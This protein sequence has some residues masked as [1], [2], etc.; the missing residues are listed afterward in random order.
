MFWLRNKKIKFSLPSLNES[1]VL[2]FCSKGTSRNYPDPSK[3]QKA[4]SV[5]FMKK[6][7]VLSDRWLSI[8]ML[9]C[10][11]IGSVCV[12]GQKIL[13]KS[14]NP[15]TESNTKLFFP[16]FF[17]NKD[18]SVHKVLL[19]LFLGDSDS[20]IH[21]H[22]GRVHLFLPGSIYSPRRC[23]TCFWGILTAPYINI[24]DGYTF[25]YLVLYTHQED[26]LLVSGGF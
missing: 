26:V 21:Q 5:A 8:V 16:S 22:R 2:V 15:K 23:P 24:E 20:P 11:E 14:R 7:Q 9:F 1:P 19:Y 12:C 25:S 6:F 13:L 3:R 17:V 18:T 4:V 10:V